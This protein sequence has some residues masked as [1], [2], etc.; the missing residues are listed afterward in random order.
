M[1]KT[2][3]LPY[4]SQPFTVRVI[5]VVPM[6]VEPWGETKHRAT[7]WLDDIQWFF[8]DE[9][10]RRGYGPKTFE[11]AYDESS[12]LVFHQINSPLPKKE[13]ENLYWKNCKNAAQDHGLRSANDVVV[14]FYEAYSITNGKVSGTGARGA[15]RGHGGEAFLSSLHLKIARK[16]WIANDNE[17]DGEVFDWISL[18]PMKGDMLSWKRR[19]RKL[20]DVS[21]SAFGVMAHELGHG[22]GL[23]HDM[24]DD[25]NRKGNLMGNGCRGMRGY[26]RPDL[27]DDFC[28]LSMRN[29][30]VLD[31][32]PFFAVRKLKPKS[33]AFLHKAIK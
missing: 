17:Y 27:T 28:V 30:I 29:A 15:Q 33:I 10:S 20:G 9:M 1:V 14:Y 26:F 19:G 13:F 3:S 32:S 21:G 24:T 23:S 8:A 4:R 31:K 6:D 11:I 12:A 16:E 7:E 18:E 2:E 22:F 5:Y 25:H